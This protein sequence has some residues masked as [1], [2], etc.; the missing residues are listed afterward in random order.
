MN[1]NRAQLIPG[2]ILIVLGISFLLMQ[3]FEFGPGLF[4]LML[5]LAFLI[6]YALTRV[7]GVLI[8]DVFSLA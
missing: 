3:Y 6:P 8:P 1:V 2:L 7:Y 5:G 4:L